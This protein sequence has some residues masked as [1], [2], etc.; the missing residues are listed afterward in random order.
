MKKQASHS[1]KPTKTHAHTLQKRF[2][3]AQR[4]RHSISSRLA[5]GYSNACENGVDEQGAEH[6]RDGLAGAAHHP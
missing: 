1:N 4:N 6:R 2:W 5:R 3:W